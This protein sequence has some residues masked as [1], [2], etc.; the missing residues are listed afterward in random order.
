MSKRNKLLTHAA[1]WEEKN[2]KPVPK[3]FVLCDC[4]YRTFLRGHSHRNARNCRRGR[5]WGEGG[6]AVAGPPGGPAW[7]AA[8][9]AWRSC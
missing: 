1:T 8:V 5:G 4:S 7:A 3:A 9:W 6:V 2:K